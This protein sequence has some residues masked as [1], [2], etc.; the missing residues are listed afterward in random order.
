[1]GQNSL[2]IVKIT[3][4]VSYC[5]VAPLIKMVLLQSILGTV[6]HL[7]L[8]VAPTYSQPQPETGGMLQLLARVEPHIQP[9]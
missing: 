9:P 7:G 6:V 8:K 2:K 3:I 5:K 4:R 1:M